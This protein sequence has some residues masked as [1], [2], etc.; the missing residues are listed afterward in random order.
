MQ[1]SP[2]VRIAGSPSK[3]MR[4]AEVAPHLPSRS[5]SEEETARGNTDRPRGPRAVSG[6]GVP[7]SYTDPLG[8]PTGFPPCNWCIGST[9]RCT[10]FDTPAS[11]DDSES[12]VA[13]W[14]VNR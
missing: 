4:R 7:Y 1:Q 11:Y 8:V 9:N 2:D 13:A 6:D 14:R 10:W 5:N 3:L 12:Y